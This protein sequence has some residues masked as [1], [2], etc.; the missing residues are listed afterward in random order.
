MWQ[1]F[2][3]IAALCWTSVAILDKFVLGHEIKDPELATVVAG[4]AIFITFFAISLAFGKILLPL[5]VIIISIIGGIGYALAIWLYYKAIKK[6]E[7]S[8]SLAW[9]SLIPLFVL[10]Y[11][12]FYLGVVLSSSKY[13][14][15]FLIVAGAI[16]ISVKKISLKG[17]LNIAVL[18][19]ILSAFFY[20]VRNVAIKHATLQTDFWSLLFWI[21]VGGAIVSLVLLIFHHPHIIRKARRGIEHLI[22]NGFLSA[23]AVVFFTIAATLGPISLVSAMIEIEPLLVFIIA[24]FISITHP[25]IIK[26]KITLRILLQKLIAISIIIAGAVLIV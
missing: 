17:K 6:E 9:L 25:G 3:L 21:G 18:F 5:N 23:I 7:L 4:S 1:I 26:E 22:I 14:G 12:Y 13:L 8:R 24:T 2:A 19:A 15:I 11:E 20:S 16:M 10:V